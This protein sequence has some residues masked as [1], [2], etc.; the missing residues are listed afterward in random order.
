[1]A[2]LRGSCA[3]A[4]LEFVTTS[5]GSELVLSALGRTW[6]ADGDCLAAWRQAERKLILLARHR[7]LGWKRNDGR[8]CWGDVLGR[9]MDV[10]SVMSAID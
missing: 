7:P 5:V 6:A 1:L 10:I 3:L 8:K 4:G 9:M 2:S